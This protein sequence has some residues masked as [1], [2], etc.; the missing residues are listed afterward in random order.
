MRILGLSMIIPSFAIL[1]FVVVYPIILAIIE[2]FKNDSGGYDFSNYVFL[3]TDHV[4][5]ANI[6]FSLEIM[7]IS[8]ILVLTISFA[9]AV[10]MRFSNGLIVEW[11]KKFY[12][13]PL[14]IPSVIATFA[15]MSFYGNHGWLARFV[16]FF[17]GGEIPRIIYDMKGIILADIWMNVPFTTI[18]LTS[19]LSGIPNSV[20]E[21]SRDVG[22]SKFMM[23]FKIILPLS[24]MTTL[25][26]ITFVFMGVIGSFTAPYLLG[27]NAPQVLGVAMRQ[28]FSVYHDT[29]L[30]STYAVFS[31]LICAIPGYFYIREMI[32]EDKAH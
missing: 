29:R 7:V 25:V 1:L 15:L 28:I 12:M 16:E 14:F 27:P 30:S 6:I 3:F 18:L 4:M 5:R 20:I 31:F 8:V 26:A 9:L 11:I 19:A 10:F 13:I 24:Y 2:S 32:K 21:S 23:F 22:A 17:G